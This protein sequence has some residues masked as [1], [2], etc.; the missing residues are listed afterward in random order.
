MK[1]PPN[2]NESRHSL[3]LIFILSVKKTSDILTNGL[4]PESIKSRGE[5]DG[6]F[7]CCN[8]SFSCSLDK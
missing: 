5:S 3:N 1:L 2:N 6:S 8:N 7:N 4:S